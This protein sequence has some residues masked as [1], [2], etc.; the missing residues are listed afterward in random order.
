MP[1]WILFTLLYGIFKGLREPFKKRALKTAGV[2]EA[3]FFYSF[4]GFLL[5]LP[6]SSDAFSLPPIF[7]LYIGIKSAVIFFAFFL[8]FLA[9]RQLPVG[10]YGVI[11]TSRVVFS[12]LLGYIVLQEPVTGKGVLGLLLVVLGIL[13]ASSSRKGEERKLK[14][15][16]LLIMLVSCLL[17]AVSGLLDKLLMAGGEISTSQLQFW[18]ML[19]LSVFYLAFIL[20]R[21]ERLHLKKNLK[22]GWIFI[23]SALLILGDRLLFLANADPMSRVTVMTVLKQS[24]ILVTI[25]CGAVFYRE[26]HLRRRL[27]AAAVV[28]L[29]ILLASL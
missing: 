20:S 5:C 8:S 29:G 10:L 25:F 2:H 26:K 21:G 28:I 24:S 15:S 13:L 14:L 3:L 6:F 9:I 1:V 11:D 27:L 17:N 12:S 23:I 4:W 19:F 16:Y 18:F 7:L 22:N